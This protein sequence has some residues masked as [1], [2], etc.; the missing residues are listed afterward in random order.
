MFTDNLGRNDIT[1]KNDAKEIPVLA[2][3]WILGTHKIKK[4]VLLKKNHSGL[5]KI[6]PSFQATK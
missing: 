5:W 6:I 2:S 3:T 4:I 1:T